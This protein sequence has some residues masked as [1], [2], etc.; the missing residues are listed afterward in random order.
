[1]TGGFCVINPEGRDDIRHFSSGAGSPGDAGHPPVNYHAYAACHS[2]SFLRRVGDLLTTTGAALV[3]LRK[4]NLRAVLKTLAELKARGVTSLISLKESGSHQVADFLNDAGRAL[5]FRRICTTADGFLSST[6]ELVSLYRSAGCRS[7]FFAP[8]PYPME[9]QAWDFSIPLS[10]RSG[11]FVGTREFRVPSRNHWHAVAL[12]TSLAERHRIPLTVVNSEGRHGRKLI[13]GFQIPTVDLQVIEGRMPYPEYLRMM[14]RHRV[15]LQLDGS[16]V[17]GQVAGD[18]LLCRMPCLG[19]NGAVDLIAFGAP[20]E[21]PSD[22]ASRLITEDT[23]WNEQVA[24][25]LARARES[26][27]F[28]AVSALIER[29]IASLAPAPSA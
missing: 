1:M 6:P 25:A 7:G 12:A 26:L 4:R 10:E 3:L 5:L 28:R 17:P 13:E 24:L 8:T 16:A 20:S 18:A 15:V 11:I 19:G 27:G 23:F 14:A 21:N 2:G 29:E 22:V 9:D